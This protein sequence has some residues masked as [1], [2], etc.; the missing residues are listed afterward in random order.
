M[1][2]IPAIDLIGG[3]CVRLTEGDYASKK[4]YHDNPAEVAKSFERL[5][6]RRLH[7][8]DLDGAKQK[9]VVNLDVLKAICEQ[10]NLKV[11]FG[12]GVR[13]DRDLENVFEAGAS[14]VTCGSVAIK[15]PELAKRW[16]LT[17]GPEKMILG[18]D[19]KGGNIAVSGWEEES[20]VHW[21]EFLDRYLHMGFQYVICTDVSRDGKL[22]GPAIELYEEIMQA[23]PGIKLI[24]SGGISSSDDVKALRSVGLYGAIIGKAIYENRITE[25]ELSA[26]I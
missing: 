23:F 20:K 10:T 2:I 9:K 14:Q 4:E 8:V 12:G 16:I 22:Q 15:D 25:Q 1:E 6:V 3:K 11:D 26:L 7:L 21:T 5:G 24:A 18:A 17:Y 19:L 13:S